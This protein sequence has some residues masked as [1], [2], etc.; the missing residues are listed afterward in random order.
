MGEKTSWFGKVLFKIVIR[1]NIFY[2]A[3]F[4]LAF[5]S[6]KQQNLPYDEKNYTH[7][8]IYIYIEIDIY[9]FIFW[10]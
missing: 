6:L 8:D 10:T 2:H 5:F 1:T 9:V 3:K 4:S 7:I